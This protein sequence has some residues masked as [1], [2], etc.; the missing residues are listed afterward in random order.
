MQIK[1][2]NIKKEPEYPTEYLFI[3]NPE[4]FNNYMPL[5]WRANKAVSSALLA[6]IL[7]G[8]NS[9]SN[10]KK[11][12]EVQVKNDSLLIQKDSMSMGK[13][14][15]PAIITEKDSLKYV[16]KKT[17]AVTLGLPNA[18]FSVTENDVK[19]S[20]YNNNDSIKVAPVFVHGDGSGVIGCVVMS[21]PVFISENDAM[22]IIS[23]EFNKVNLLIDTNNLPIISFQADAIADYCYQMEF[24]SKKINAGA[25]TNKSNQAKLNIEMSGINKKNNLLIKFVTKADYFKFHSDSCKS[26]WSIKS[27]NTK[28]AAQ[29]IQNELAKKSSINAVVF[30]DPIAYMNFDDDDDIEKRDSLGNIINTDY[31]NI[32]DDAKKG[33]K[34]LLTAQ[35]RDFIQWMKNEGM[36]K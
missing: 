25:N 10:D 11:Q 26:G 22:E 14:A 13:A 31:D 3:N 5:R 34:E 2:I 8:A 4:L 18:D 16:V 1:P 15:P 9:C 33:A 6:F 27:L 29:L 23:K 19:V 28:K 36:I 30:Y 21:A 35:V 17:E 7:A 24:A 20:K 32:R 12:I